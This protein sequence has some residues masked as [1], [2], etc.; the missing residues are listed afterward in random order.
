MYFQLPCA[1]RGKHGRRSHAVWIQDQ[2]W[3]RIFWVSLPPGVLFVLG[4]PVRDRVA[5]LAF[6]AWKKDAGASALLRSRTPEQ[7][8]FE[9][10][11]MEATAQA[12]GAQRSRERRDS[13]LRRKYAI[14]FLLACIILFATRLTGVNSIIGYKRRHSAQSGLSDLQAHWGLCDF[15]RGELPDDHGGN[16]AGRSQGAQV[17]ADSGHRRHSRLAVWGWPSVSAHEK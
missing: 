5:A 3:R 8:G 1:G 12:V 11:E 14:P 13:L 9:L 7:A 17:P 2:A 4:R 16:D 10:A 15:Y 6:Q